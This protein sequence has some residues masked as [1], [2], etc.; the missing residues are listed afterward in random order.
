MTAPPSVRLAVP[1]MAIPTALTHAVAIRVSWTRRATDLGSSFMASPSP[2]LDEESSRTSRFQALGRRRWCW[3]GALLA[4]DVVLGVVVGEDA[5]D[6][7]P[8]FPE[9]QHQRPVVLPRRDR[10]P[11]LRP[12][13]RREIRDP[14]L[15][16][17]G[18][19]LEP[20][21]LLVATDVDEP[22]HFRAYPLVTEGQ[23]DEASRA[24]ALGI[25]CMA[26]GARGS[27]PPHA[28]RP[29]MARSAGSSPSPASMVTIR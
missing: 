8:P 19:D 7:R 13:V 9:R 22:V 17:R 1:A 27:S 26:W 2:R 3:R 5:E 6:V 12:V 24:R 25:G 14:E 29:A 11:R 10:I 21:V 28:A 16:P 4:G 20:D 18:R 23:G 15:V